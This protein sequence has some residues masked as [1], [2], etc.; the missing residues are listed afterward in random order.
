MLH[1]SQQHTRAILPDDVE[2][3]P[4]IKPY[5]GDAIKLDAVKPQADPPVVAGQP[6]HSRMP[7]LIAGLAL[8]L[9]AAVGAGFWWG[10]YDA[11]QKMP[12]L[13]PVSGQAPNVPTQAQPVSPVTEPGLFRPHYTTSIGDGPLSHVSYSD[14]MAPYSDIYLHQHH[15][16]V[17]RIWY[18]D[19]PNGCD[20]VR[21]NSNKIWFVTHAPAAITINDQTIARISQDTIVDGYSFDWSVK[22]GDRVCLNGGQPGTTPR[23][24]YLWVG[25]DVYKWQD[26]HCYRGNCVAY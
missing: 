22:V 25:P 6:H 8:V 21:I 1:E 20:T 7:L 13:A 11:S 18:Q 2:P 23:S 19:Q 9:F 14:G 3:E 4:L 24:F 12:I 10:A 15:D 16:N 26:S 5:P 17:Q